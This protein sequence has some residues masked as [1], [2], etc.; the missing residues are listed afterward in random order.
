[1]PRD[2]DCNHRNCYGEPCKQLTDEELAP[3]VDDFAFAAEAIK[4]G[5]LQV[6]HAFRTLARLPASF[7]TAADMIRPEK[8]KTEH[9]RELA[10]RWDQYRLWSYR[11]NNDTEKLTLTVKQFRAFKLL[12]GGVA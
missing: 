2:N 10:Q 6:S 5:W 11:C 7:P 12:Y 3:G 1:M 4:D 9:G 8:L